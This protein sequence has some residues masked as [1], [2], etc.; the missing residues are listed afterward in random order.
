MLA[1]PLLVAATAVG[2]RLRLSGGAPVRRGP[3][4]RAVALALLAFAATTACAASAARPPSVA[5]LGARTAIAGERWAGT[6]RVA[7]ASAGRPTVV[8]DGPGGRLRAR[9]TRA[10]SGRWRVA[11]TFSRA[12]RW[13]LSARV[14]RRTLGLGAVTVRP[15]FRPLELRQPGGIA[16]APD[17]SLVV[18][19]QGENRVIRIDPATG[20][21]RLLAETPRPWGIWIAPDGAVLFSSAGDVVRREP[22][23]RTT[24]IARFAVD[25][26]PV[27]VAPGGDVLVG[28]ADHRVYRIRGGAV[29]PYAG[30]G[31]ELST[32]HGFAFPADGSLLVSDTGNDRIARVD[33]TT[34]AVTTY[35]DGVRVP[36]GIALGPDGSLYVTESQGRRVTR[37][38][39][40]GRRLTVAEFDVPT[41]VAVDRSGV[42]YV[43]EWG[44]GKGHIRRVDSDG[45]I[46]TLGRRFG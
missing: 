1:G 24:T 25:A 19:V 15:G 37:I 41:Q 9:G 22:D 13:R 18:A 11:L 31:A 29:E 2:R 23:G 28:V 21:T 38:D 44:K 43:V 27:A 33:G 30:G 34:R 40:A 10:G 35:A 42:L 12:G 4:R 17:G 46:S 32:P 26:G 3:R 7:P 45:T 20:A 16:V 36:N 14:G 8:A 39:A 5:L 6:V